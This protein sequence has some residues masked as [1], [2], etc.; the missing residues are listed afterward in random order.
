MH[1]GVWHPRQ[2]ALNTTDL[3]LDRITKWPGASPTARYRRGW[4]VN[5]RRHCGMLLN[6]H[7]FSRADADVTAVVFRWTTGAADDLHKIVPQIILRR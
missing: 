6:L 1:A 7:R 5:A 2:P 3:L 4:I